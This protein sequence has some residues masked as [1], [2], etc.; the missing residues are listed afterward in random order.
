MRPLPFAQGSLLL[1][2][3]AVCNVA[4][5]LL[6]PWS[7]RKLYGSPVKVRIGWQSRPKIVKIPS[8]PP[9]PTSSMRKI[10]NPC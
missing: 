3:S 7:I 10:L 9:P 2:V 8:P 5:L 6:A 4:F 1:S